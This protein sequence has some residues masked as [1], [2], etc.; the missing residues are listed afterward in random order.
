MYNVFNVFGYFSK[1]ASYDIKI[2]GIVI[3]CVALICVL[4]TLTKK[5]E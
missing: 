4:P 3:A 2:V 5:G 1:V